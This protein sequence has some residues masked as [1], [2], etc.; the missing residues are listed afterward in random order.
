MRVLVKMKMCGGFHNIPLPTATLAEQALHDDQSIIFQALGAPNE[1]DWMKI[2]SFITRVAQ[3][4]SNSRY[5]PLILLFAGLCVRPERSLCCQRQCSPG[6]ELK[7]C[8]PFIG[9]CIDS[10]TT[11]TAF[12]LFFTLN[13]ALISEGSLLRCPC[14][15]S[16]PKG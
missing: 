2:F 1:S 3:I 8:T 15:R 11:C 10:L 14:Q 6:N 4:F 12:S 9:E 5:F 7:L 16:R 13:S